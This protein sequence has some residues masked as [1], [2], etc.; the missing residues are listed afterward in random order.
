[1]QVTSWMIWIIYLFFIS[2]SRGE[3]GQSPAPPWVR[4][5]WTCKQWAVGGR[6]LEQ[7]SLICVADRVV[8][9][10]RQR[11]SVVS[12]HRWLVSNDASW[13]HW[14][15]LNAT[16]IQGDRTDTHHNAMCTSSVRWVAAYNVAAAAAVKPTCNLKPPSS[17][18]PPPVRMVST[19][20]VLN[21][22]SHTAEK[23]WIGPIQFW[24]DRAFS[25]TLAIFC[26]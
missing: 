7:V 14:P 17:P 11:T 13:V 8:G 12:T 9:R 22:R 25:S 20:S 19:G 6:P 1:M 24:L 21:R 10:L 16:S 23:Y 5:W 4:H 26:V 18:L 15:P 2:T 3:R